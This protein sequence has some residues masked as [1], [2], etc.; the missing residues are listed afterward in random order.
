MNLIQSL[1]KERCV[2]CKTGE[3]KLSGPE[4]TELMAALPDWKLVNHTLFRRLEFKDFAK[5]LRFVNQLSGLAEEEGHHPDISFGWGYAEIELTTHAA[6]GLS[7]NDFI[8]AA[9]VD[10]LLGVSAG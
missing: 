5:A 3:G 8:L 6:G 1:Q 2:P 10:T 7:R 9:K 4:V